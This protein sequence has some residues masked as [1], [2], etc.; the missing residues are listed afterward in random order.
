MAVGLVISH[1]ILYFY[2]DWQLTKTKPP[3]LQLNYLKFL[4]LIILK[5]MKGY[6]RANK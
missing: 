5:E 6:D 4:T 1:R 3:Y 2:F